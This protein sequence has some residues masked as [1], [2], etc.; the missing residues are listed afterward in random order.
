MVK[1]VGFE[2]MIRLQRDEDAKAVAEL[3]DGGNADESADGGDDQP[4]VANSVA[5]DRPTVE[6][7]E[8]RWQPGEHERDDNQ[9]NEN[10]TAGGIFAPA[11]SETA[12]SGKGVSDCASQRENDEADARRIGKESCPIAPTPNGERKKRQGAADSKSEVLDR[13]IQ[14]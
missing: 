4:Q 13:V 2:A 12:A 3:K 8:M 5:V 9:R 10:P 11:D 1:A 7:I 14:N 6:T